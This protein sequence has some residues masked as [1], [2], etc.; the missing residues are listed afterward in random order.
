MKVVTGRI[1]K[2]DRAETLRYLGYGRKD[3]PT[4]EISALLDE[5]EELIIKA[6]NLQAVYDIYGISLGQPLDLGFARVESR[7][8]EKNLA[9]CKKIVLFAATAGM[10]VDRLIAK[11]GRLSSARAAVLQAMG[12]ALAEE[13]CDKLHSSLIS[14]YGANKSRF[15]CGFGD[16]PLTLQ[17]DVFAALN[18]TKNIG[19]TLS[20]NCFM[21][22]TKSVTAIIGIKQQ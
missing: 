1:E 18:V 9:G 4:E 2:I 5:C 8:L 13:W 19:V 17:R 3:K 15:S 14:E 22:P 12:A 16:L 7:D 21:T 11:Y 6:Q 10:G 20:D